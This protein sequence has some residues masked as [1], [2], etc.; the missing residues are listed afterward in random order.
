[1]T[2]QPMTPPS[3][4]SS[5][6][7]PVDRFLTPINEAK[8]S[9]E[10]LRFEPLYDEVKKLREQDDASLP[11]GV[12][13]RELKRADWSGVAQLCESAL[14]F[15]TKDLQIAAWL[16][17]AWIHQY[18]FRG[19]QRGLQVVNALCNNFWDTLHP[20]IED[21]A[22]E[23][24]ISPLIWMSEK[25][26]LPIKSIPVTAPTGDEAVIYAWRDWEAGLY[27]ANLARTNAASAS[28]AEAQGMVP[29]SK[30]LV[31]VSLTPAAWISILSSDVA[32]A[33]ASI[34]ELQKT[35]NAKLGEIMAPS[36]TSLRTPLESIQTFV[37]R[38]LSERI[39]RGELAPPQSAASQ[40]Q[41]PIAREEVPMSSTT[42]EISAPSSSGVIASRAEA[43]LKLREAADFLMRTEPHSPVPYLIRRAISWGNLSLGE[44]LEELLHKNAD[45]ATVYTLLGIKKS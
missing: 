14:E 27:L 13:R 37:A 35:L 20:L 10:W 6:I 2:I 4:E 25:L 36:L 1:M 8:P 42:M 33:I 18:G 7:A 31:S 40:P 44:L 34:D 45:L 3:S 41:I 9:G 5:P 16:T 30:F 12:W 23:A 17:E 39:E 22:I 29:Q 32:A 21:G 28:T 15:K 19:L 38:V 24:R 43:Y 11:Q 26:V